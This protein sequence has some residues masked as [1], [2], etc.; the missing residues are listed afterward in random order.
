MEAV[1]NYQ[2][3]L[4]K[5]VKGQYEPL[6]KQIDILRRT[7]TDEAKTYSIGSGKVDKKEAKK[8]CDSGDAFEAAFGT[9]FSALSTAQKTLGARAN[10]L[11]AFK[12]DV[13]KFNSSFE[14]DL[15]K[16]EAQRQ[17][18]KTRLNKAAEYLKKKDFVH[19]E[20]L[21]K[22]ILTK[23]AGCGLQPRESYHK[24]MEV[25]RNRK[26][27]AFDLTTEDVQCFQNII[28]IGYDRCAEFDKKYASIVNYKELAQKIITEVEVFSSASDSDNGKWKKKAEGDVKRIEEIFEKLTTAVS[29][30][31]WAKRVM[32]GNT[33]VPESQINSFTNPKATA[34]EKATAK[35]MILKA[36][37]QNEAALPKLREAIAKIKR[38]AEK[39]G[40]AFI[41]NWP[42]RFQSEDWFSK[43]KKDIESTVR[44]IEEAVGD[45]ERK[46]DAYMAKLDYTKKAIGVK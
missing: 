1:K 17:D 16:L 36:I 22:V 26:P 39:E 14:K 31:G 8:I 45:F 15:Q 25:H 2:S 19:A 11:V 21:A 24:A 29:I 9:Y 38:A 5:Q 41:S 7:A 4:G 44:K 10:G 27:K 33:P 34:E 18:I 32:E 37:E 35:G 13:E 23:D 12:A 20:L 40:P 3:E 46:Y 6:K 30:N 43:S 42:S 28:K